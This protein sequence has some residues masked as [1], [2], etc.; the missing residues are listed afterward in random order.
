MRTVIVVQQ[1]ITENIW[2]CS[3]LYIEFYF[4]IK[5][6]FGKISICPSTS[7]KIV[8]QHKN[9][10]KD[11]PVSFIVSSVYYCSVLNYCLNGLLFLYG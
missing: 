1:D 6:H 7:L 2:L 11:C 9:H 8:G 10:L 5:L 3:T 4:E